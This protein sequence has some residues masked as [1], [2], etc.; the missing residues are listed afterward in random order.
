MIKSLNNKKKN[1]FVMYLIKNLLKLK[2]IIVI[3]EVKI[4]GKI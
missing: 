2:K 1:K 3:K 4:M